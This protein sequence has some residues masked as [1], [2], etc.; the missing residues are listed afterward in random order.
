MFGIIAPKQYRGLSA[1]R[2]GSS[3]SSWQRNDQSIILMV[4]LF[5]QWETE[6]QQQKIQ[7][8][9]CQKCYK[10]IYICSTGSLVW[11]AGSH[12]QSHTRN[13]FSAPWTMWYTLALVQVSS[14][15]EWGT[16]NHVTLTQLHQVTCNVPPT[17][18]T[19]MNNL[20]QVIQPS[21]AR[22]RPTT[23]EWEDKR[24][25]S[26]AVS[27]LFPWEPLQIIYSRWIWCNPHHQGLAKY[28]ARSQLVTTGLTT[29]DDEPENY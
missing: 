6:Q 27:Y 22:V 17:K 26:P 9:A 1:D 10:L 12:P 4:G 14:S 20:H 16:K 13:A 15:T 23:R 19:Q 2:Y 5:E 24:R 8:N 21:P 11:L 25:K 3:A 28:L 18:H 7:K 29:F